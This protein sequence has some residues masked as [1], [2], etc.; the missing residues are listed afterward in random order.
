MYL[1][2]ETTAKPLSASE[3]IKV[4]ASLNCNSTSGNHFTV[5]C[6]Y[7]A[8]RQRKQQPPS[9]TGKG[10]TQSP[11]SALSVLFRSSVIYSKDV[12]NVYYS[13]GPMLSGPNLILI[14]KEDTAQECYGISTRLS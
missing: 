5:L 1:E 11:S 2:N 14:L 4:S 6:V 13:P 12:L 7:S 3:L 10:E 8:Q 9:V